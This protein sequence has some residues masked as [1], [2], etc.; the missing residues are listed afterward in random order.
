MVCRT[1]FFM[2]R[3]GPHMRL[4]QGVGRHCRPD[5]GIITTGL[6]LWCAWSY[7]QWSLPGA[8]KYRFRAHG[9]GPGGCWQGSRMSLH[10]Q[11]PSRPTLCPGLIG[12]PPNKGDPSNREDL[13][14]SHISPVPPQLGAQLPRRKITGIPEVVLCW[15]L[16]FL[17]FF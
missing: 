6:L 14:L 16:V 7:L 11:Q 9:Q 13:Q 3:F 10:G 1:L 12:D 4:E 15:I 17:M 2:W 5:P 8:Q